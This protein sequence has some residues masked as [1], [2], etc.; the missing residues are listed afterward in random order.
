MQGETTN[1]GHNQK[2]TVVQRSQLAQAWRKGDY[3]GKGTKGIQKIRKKR[4]GGGVQEED[5]IGRRRR[6]QR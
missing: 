2:A 5:E 4:S 6:R 3:D 1:E